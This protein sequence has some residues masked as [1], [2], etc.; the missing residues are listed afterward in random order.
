MMQTT[1]STTSPN[2]FSKHDCNKIGLQLLSII[3]I[4]KFSR[5]VYTTTFVGLQ[6]YWVKAVLILKIW[7]MYDLDPQNS[8]TKIGA[9]TKFE[10]YWYN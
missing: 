7:Y 6:P 4:I 9:P 8:S 3:D 5:N 10:Y 2:I 1:Y